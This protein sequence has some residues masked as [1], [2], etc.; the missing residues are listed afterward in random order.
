[1]AIYCT[2]YN[3]SKFILNKQSP[4]HL[5]HRCFTQSLRW[6]NE[7]LLTL[8][9]RFYEWRIIPRARTQMKKVWL[10]AI[11]REWWHDRSTMW[12]LIAVRSMFVSCLSFKIDD[13]EIDFSDNSF[14]R[15]SVRLHSTKCRAWIWEGNIIKMV[16]TNNCDMLQIIYTRR[17]LIVG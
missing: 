1:M 14:I 5:S 8:G 7:W 17:P 10:P 15:S 12:W 13:N 11:N 6:N 4:I 3:L 9:M 2:V 16:I